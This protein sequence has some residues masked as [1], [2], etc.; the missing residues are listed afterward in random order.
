MCLETRDGAAGER[1]SDALE[2]EVPS[3]ICVNTYYGRM[4]EGHLYLDG[5]SR[6]TWHTSFGGM[7]LVYTA[8]PKKSRPS[9]RSHRINPGKTPKM[10][11]RNACCAPYV[12]HFHCKKMLAEYRGIIEQL[13][14]EAVTLTNELQRLGARR[15]G[16]PWKQAEPDERSFRQQTN[17]YK[18]SISDLAEENR[19]LRR[20]I[21]AG[22]ARWHRV[23]EADKQSMA[24][25]QLKDI[26]REEREMAMELHMVGRFPTRMM[27]RRIDGQVFFRFLP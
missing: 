5:A 16:P 17:L 14:R 11:S 2:R 9:S 10:S 23:S 24:T 13:Q 27:A 8:A 1:S 7:F 18:D 15:H 6:H 3:S 19:E 12:D 4:Q 22:D 26:I 21:S 25:E 20:Q